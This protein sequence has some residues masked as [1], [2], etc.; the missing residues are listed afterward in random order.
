MNSPSQKANKFL[1][2]I[3]D[4]KMAFETFFTRRVTRHSSLFTR[5]FFL[6][7]SP[8]VDL[9]I[10]SLISVSAWMFLNL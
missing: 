9:E 3:Y 8:P 5:H 7:P 1:Y 10:E 4:G 6:G 2:K